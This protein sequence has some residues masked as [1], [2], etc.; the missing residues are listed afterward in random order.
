MAVETLSKAADFG[1]GGVNVGKF[2]DE[3]R[4]ESAITTNLLGVTASED[5]DVVSCEFSAA[6]SGSE[7]TA[8]EALAANHIPTE[9]PG[10][11]GLSAQTLMWEDDGTILYEGNELILEG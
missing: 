9:S 2:D 11:P 6:L 1:S 4:A 10:D 7:R 3:I 5:S 8:L